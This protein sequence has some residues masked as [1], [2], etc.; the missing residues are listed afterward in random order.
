MKFFECFCLLATLGLAAAK[1]IPRNV[2]G[3]AMMT[4][5]GIDCSNLADFTSFPHPHWCDMFMMCW[6]GES[7]EMDCEPGELFDVRTSFCED[8]ATV[9]CVDTPPPENNPPPNPP[10]VD[11]DGPCPPPGSDELVFLPSTY[12]DEYYI[13]INGNPILRT[14]RPGL[15]WN[16]DEGG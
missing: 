15:H 4:H 5:F 9:D 14:C 7:H 3:T 12:C 6:E 11:H 1:S 16:I 10:D 2:N 8:A 13:C